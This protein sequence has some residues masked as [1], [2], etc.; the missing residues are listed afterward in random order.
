[1]PS[2]LCTVDLREENRINGSSDS[3]GV[4]RCVFNIVIVEGTGGQMP[5]NLGMERNMKETRNA[6]VEV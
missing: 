1:M 6:G 4:A 3:W 2:V 5:K